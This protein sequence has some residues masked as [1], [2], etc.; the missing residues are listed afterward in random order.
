MTLV[1][2]LAPLK[3]N[4]HQDRI[5]AVLY[6]CERYEQQPSLTIDT[7]RK[8]LK[9][10]RARGASTVNIADVLSKSGAFTD[11][12]GLDG[13][14]RLWKLT[15]SGREYVRHLLGLPGNEPEIEH[16]VATLTALVSKVSNDD[17]RNYLEEALKCLQ[18]DALRACVV[19]VWTAAVRTI[20]TEVMTRGSGAV[21]TAIQRHDPR[22]R[23]IAK[24]DDFAYIK[25]SVL[26]L[27]ASDLGLLDKNEKDALTEALNLRNRCGHPSKYRP[28]VKKVSAFVEDITSIVFA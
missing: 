7:I 10:A 6:Y 21:T 1:E 11:T 13:T 27:A 22:A 26:L 14:R 24:I 19:F 2:F 20:Q 23:P 8:R 12:D 16:D 3:T 28:G 9:G 25:E 18:V 5:L 17:V 15:E 4:K